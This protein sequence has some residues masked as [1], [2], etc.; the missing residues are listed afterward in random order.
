M[1]LHMGCGEPLSGAWHRGRAHVILVSAGHRPEARGACYQDFCEW[2]EAMQ[3]ASLIVN[4]IGRDGLLV[5]TGHL[6]DKVSFINSHGATLALE[7]HF[8]SA[9]D[10]GGNHVGEGCETL[11]MPLSVDGR[12]CAEIVQ[13]ALAEVF[14]PDRGVKPGWY[15]GDPTNGPIFFLK[16]TTCPALIIEPEFIHRRQV[17]QD[18]REA[19]CQRIATALTEAANSIKEV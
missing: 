2:E 12:R 13:R 10:R 14:Q 15:Q 5:P 3:W 19:A 4:R 16:G 7:V 11:Y 6:R 9:V 8:N 1:K 18:S 17:I